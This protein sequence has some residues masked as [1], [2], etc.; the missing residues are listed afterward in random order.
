MGSYAS[1]PALIADL[2]KS[3]RYSKSFVETWIVHLVRPHIL[4]VRLHIKCR[5]DGHKTIH[6]G[7]LQVARANFLKIRYAPLGNKNV[8]AKLSCLICADEFL[9]QRLTRSFSGCGD[10][11]GIRAKRTWRSDLCWRSIS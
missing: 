6:P 1:N 8:S 3:L 7:V 4:I 11:L 2:G 5:S 10:G 9:K